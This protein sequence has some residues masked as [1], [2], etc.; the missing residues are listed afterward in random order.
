VITT[1]TRKSNLAEMLA[2][3]LAISATTL[4]IVMMDWLE[5][6]LNQ[7]IKY[8]KPTERL[9]STVIHT[10][11]GLLS[12][13]FSYRQEKFLVLFSAVWYSFI[14]LSAIRNWWIPYI[15]GIVDGEISVEEY[16]EIYSKNYTILPSLGHPII[17]DVQHMYIHL[18]LLLTVF[19]CAIH[20][21]TLL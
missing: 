3:I 18:G 21:I 16:K 6:P 4:S 1:K 10:S 20:F 8:Q 13:F 19:S 15:Y 5:T 9:P 14:L 2:S 11:V 7:N 17:P 12:I